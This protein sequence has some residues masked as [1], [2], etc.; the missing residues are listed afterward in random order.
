MIIDFPLLFKRSLFP[1]TIFIKNSF[2]MTFD[3][4]TLALQYFQSRCNPQQ[5]KTQLHQPQPHSQYGYND[6][7][8]RP[9]CK[10]PEKTIFRCSL[11]RQYIA[12]VQ[13]RRSLHQIEQKQTADEPRRLDIASALA[14]E[15]PAGLHTVQA[16]VDAE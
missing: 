10:Y 1:A 9:F 2:C 15:P 5:S 7:I 14:Q 12:I 13:Q 4:P 11:D 8:K 3:E 16:V 6:C